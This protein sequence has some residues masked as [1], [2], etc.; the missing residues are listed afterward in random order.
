M[1]I[2]GF[3]L[4][5]YVTDDAKIFRVYYKAKWWCHT[6]SIRTY[7]LQVLLFATA[8]CRGSTVSSH[9]VGRKKNDVAKMRQAGTA[10]AT[11]TTIYCLSSLWCYVIYKRCSVLLPT[12]F[13][14]WMCVSYFDQTYVMSDLLCYL[15]SYVCYA[16][17]CAECRRFG[18]FRVAACVTDE[19]RFID[20][21][22][23]KF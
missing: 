11:G 8:A 13:C 22:G 14:E 19:V 18:V 9:H 12:H 5:S 17:S 20:L 15:S 7:S 16:Q 4:N 6:S 2:V 21:N 3:C 1:R 10:P 23:S